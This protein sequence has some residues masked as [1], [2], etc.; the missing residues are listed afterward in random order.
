MYNK[1]KRFTKGDIVYVLAPLVSELKTNRKKYVMDY[2]GPLAVAEVLDDTHY[3]LQLVTDNQDI[4]P[5][6]WH[7]NRLKPGTELTPEGV[8]RSK[9]MLRQHLQ[10]SQSQNDALTIIPCD[11]YHG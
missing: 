5:G 3:K 10:G 11:T 6:I 7:I 2:I 1:V 8:A 4:L 9:I